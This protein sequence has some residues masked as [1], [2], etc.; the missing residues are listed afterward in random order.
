MGTSK[1]W[2]EVG[3]ATS[4]GTGMCDEHAAHLN[5]DA[6]I[7]ELAGALCEGICAAVLAAAN[8]AAEL[9]P[10]VQHQHHL[11]ADPSHSLTS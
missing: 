11:P 3:I 9:L 8:A 5:C 1:A 2:D 10:L 7:A 6:Q 4:W